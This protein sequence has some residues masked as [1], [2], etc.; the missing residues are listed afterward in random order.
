[1]VCCIG[2]NNGRKKVFDIA[3]P[4]QTQAVAKPKK[5]LL[6]EPTEDTFEATTAPELTTKSSANVV[7]RKSMTI[8]PIVA[9]EAASTAPVETVPE[10]AMAKEAETT[11]PEQP[12]AEAEEEELETEEQIVTETAEPEEEKPEEPEEEPAAP[13]KE[14]FGMVDAGLDDSQRA[15]AAAKEAM[16]EPKIYDTKA[17]YVPI[18]N[19][20]HKHGHVAGA[21]VAGILTAAAVAL[22]VLYFGDYL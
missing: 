9:E 7:S 15:T 13:I 18:G 6:Q 22:A 4:E 12:E 10:S 1:M 19:S 14:S 11:E 21:I 3:H 16:Q 17:Y 5:I 8:E 20:H 2:L